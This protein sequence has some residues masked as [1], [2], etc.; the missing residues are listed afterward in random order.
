V[1]QNRYLPEAVVILALGLQMTVPLR[2]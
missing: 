1:E 2:S